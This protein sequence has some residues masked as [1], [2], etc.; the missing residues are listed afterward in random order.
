MKTVNSRSDTHK[1]FVGYAYLPKEKILIEGDDF[2]LP[3]H[4]PWCPWLWIS[5]TIS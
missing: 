4:C 5:P 1:G 3:A 2:T